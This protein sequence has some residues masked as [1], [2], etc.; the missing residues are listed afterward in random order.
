MHLLVEDEVRKKAQK[1]HTVVKLYSQ[2][3]KESEFCQAM[4]FLRSEQ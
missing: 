1:K 4:Y 2:I 3:E